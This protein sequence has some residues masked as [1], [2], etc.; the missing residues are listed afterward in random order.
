MHHGC[1]GSGSFLLPAADKETPS[2]QIHPAA[3]AR[4]GREGRGCR[5]LM[6]QSQLGLSYVINY[7]LLLLGLIRGSVHADGGG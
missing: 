7:W 3:S 5:F 1:P 6:L 2:P 4:R